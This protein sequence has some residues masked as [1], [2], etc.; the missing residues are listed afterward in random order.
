[1]LLLSCR[2]SEFRKCDAFIGFQTDTPAAVV[3]QAA[4]LLRSSLAMDRSES[5]IN[6]NDCLPIMAWSK[7]APEYSHI[8]EEEHREEWVKAVSSEMC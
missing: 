5:D 1:M 6:C 2:N 3:F 8:N 7:L 4:N